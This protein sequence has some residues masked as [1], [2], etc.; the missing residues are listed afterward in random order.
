MKPPF[1]PDT[2]V[3]AETALARGPTFC[4]GARDT[5]SHGPA[6]G[7]R[8]SVQ[9]T[10]VWTQYLAGSSDLEIGEL[11]CIGDAFLSHLS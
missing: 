9:I 6:G 5:I 4:N 2:E 3:L 1:A 10:G 7:G 8:V 11:G